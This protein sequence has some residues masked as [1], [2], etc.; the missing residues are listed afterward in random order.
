MGYCP[1]AFA[2]GVAF[3]WFGVISHVMTIL[4]S[5]SLLPLEG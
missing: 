5:I 3:L 4:I 1:K 2:A